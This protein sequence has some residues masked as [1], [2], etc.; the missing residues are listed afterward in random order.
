MKFWIL[1]ALAGHLA[2]AVAFLIDK[3]LLNATLKHSATYA[4]LIG[5]TSL[6]GLLFLPFVNEWPDAGLL[7]YCAAFGITFVLALWGFFEALKQGE[8]S[9]VVP[10]VGSLV[11]LFTLMG[12]YV[13]FTERLTADQTIGFVLLL[14]ATWVLARGKTTKRLT[15]RTLLIC[16]LSAVLFAVA[17]LFGKYV[18][19]RMDFAGAFVV[20]RLFAAATGVL[21][22][23]F[24]IGAQKEIRE[25][26]R[27]K[28]ATTQRTSLAW[29]VIGQLFGGM[30]F[31]MV[32]LAIKGGSPSI[33][34]ALQAVQYGSIVLVAWFG[35]HRIRKLLK[36]E[37][38]PQVMLVKTG[39]ILAIGLGLALI[40]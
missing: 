36:E 32:H 23:F 38:T 22:G 39:A 13:F 33:V 27:P 10:V 16:V 35:G 24:H 30:G 8:A 29:P 1:L 40:A 14:A 2:N 20:S 6:L 4:A 31:I 3:A 11:P 15:N 21:I 28:S 5:T 37:R 26:L 12:A 34:N 7:V 19:D 17:S 9:R 25:F 18:F